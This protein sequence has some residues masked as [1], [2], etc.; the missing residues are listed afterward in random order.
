MLFVTRLTSER[1]MAKMLH[2]VTSY[3]GS[4]MGKVVQEVFGY[5][6]IIGPARGGFREQ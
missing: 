5:S 2:N 6:V 3:G 1:N 4:A